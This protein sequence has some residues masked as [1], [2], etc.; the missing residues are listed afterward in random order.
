ME[1]IVD[2]GRLPEPDEFSSSNEIIGELGSLKRAFAM[3]RR[4]TGVEDWER[5]RQERS[6]DLLIYLALANFRRRPRFSELPIDLQRDVRTFFGAYK[7]ACQQADQLLFQVGDADAIDEACKRSPFGKLLPNAL[8]V[9]RSSLENLEPI[10]R[11]YEGCAHGYLGE[12][13]GANVIKLHRFS[14]KI[15][16]LVYPDFDRDPHPQLLRSLKVSL[17]S[18]DFHWYDYSLSENPPI[19]HRKETMLSQDHPL[20]AKFT[21]LTQQEERHGLLSDSSTIGTRNG[22]NAR[23]AEFG[24]THRGHRLI[25]SRQHE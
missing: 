2:R 16:Y 12:I 10:L 3:I 20:H 7:R 25:R 21:R 22:W 8:Y 5:I 15:S 11:I 1:W 18:R 14:G 6:D 24:F 23:L 17:R 19:L 4:V 13:D 9:H